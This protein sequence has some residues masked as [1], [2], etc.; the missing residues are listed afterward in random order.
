MIGAGDFVRYAGVC[1]VMFR[2]WLLGSLL[3][4][5]ALCIPY[6]NSSFE[7]QLIIWQWRVRIILLA[8]LLVKG[9]E[10]L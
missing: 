8:H 9:A 7:Q 2:G 6:I 4:E 5:R 3:I 1:V 10:L